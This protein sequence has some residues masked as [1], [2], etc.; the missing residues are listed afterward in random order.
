MPRL[1]PLHWKKL[2]CIFTKDGYA[3]HR[4]EGSHRSYFKAG[5]IRPLVIPTYDSVGLDIIKG[6]MRTAGMSRERFF[7]LLAKC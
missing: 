1:T 6:L 7:S 3:L 4:T 2:D 5:C